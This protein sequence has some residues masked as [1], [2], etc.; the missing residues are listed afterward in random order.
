MKDADKDE[1]LERAKTLA[2]PIGRGV[3]GSS[4]G[5]GCCSVVGKI[6]GSLCNKGFK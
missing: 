3:N 6:L 5:R 2:Q 1:L 4:Q